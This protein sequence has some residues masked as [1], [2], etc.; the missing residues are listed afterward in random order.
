MTVSKERAE[1]LF[2]TMV[3][4][5]KFEE[6]ACGLYKRGLIRGAMHVYTGQEA[7]AAGACDVIE[8]EDYI[9]STHRGHGHCIAKGGELDK[10]AA[11][12]L[13]KS[14]GYCGGKGGSMHI[15]DP[16]L[17]IL[18][19]NGI[20]GGSIGLAAGAGLTSKM[21]DTDRVTICFFGDGASNQGIFHE[22]VNLAAIW[23]L[24]VVYLCENNKYGISGP[25]EE[26]VAIDD[27]SERAA[28]YDIPG[29]TIDGND[30]LEVAEAVEE[31]VER[32]RAGEGPSLIEAKTYRW[33][34]HFVGDP[35]VYIPEGEL[36][37][38]KEKCP[39]ERFKNYVTEEDILEKSRL[40]KIEEAVEEEIEE[41]EEFAKQSP[42]PAK[43][44]LYKDVFA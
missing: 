26:M 14:T 30:V 15:A 17:G 11:E 6:M 22:S 24:P 5:R 3:T 29:K 43:E 42:E 25:A 12:L 28:A 9:T 16:N 23:D 35:C 10:M 2:E 8:E 19:A 41:A 13:G 32:A 20:V 31:A 37:K 21:K 40:Q 4:I 7:V 33:K 39:I 18:G 34:G 36:E 38:W 27:V 44:D 1:D